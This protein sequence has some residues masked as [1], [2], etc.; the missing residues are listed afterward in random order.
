MHRLKQ[1][2]PLLIQILIVC[3]V[4]LL[5]L[6]QY[7]P[8]VGMDYKYFIPRLIDSH[9]HY[10]IN[11][12]SIQWYTPSFGGGL[13]S[14]PNPQQIQ[15]SLPQAFTLFMD[16]WN[17]SLAAICVF[18]ALG[19]LGAYLLSKKRLGLTTE[20]SLTVALF[21]TLNGFTL[22][23]L[24]IGHLTFMGY[25][26]LPLVILGLT[27]P[28]N[29]WWNSL[30]VGWVMAVL[31]Y[32]G[33]FYA[34]VYIIFAC[35]LFLPLAGLFFP[36]A[37]Q[38]KFY[39]RNATIG[40]II[41]LA[42]SASKLY[43][44]LSFLRSFPRAIADEY[45][46][47]FI[48]G[49]LAIPLQLLGSMSLSFYG[50]AT[51]KTHKFTWD[52]LMTYTGSNLPVWE[53]DIS[54]S[55]ALF[56]LMIVGVTGILANLWKNKVRLSAQQWLNALALVAVGVV[57]VEFITTKGQLYA[58]L[59]GLPI[60][61]SLHVNP[62][63]TAVLILPLSILA[64][65][66]LD[67][68]YRWFFR[69]AK[70]R[71]ALWAII[72]AITIASSS[73]YFLLPMDSLQRRQFSVDGS[74]SVW[75][76]IRAGE[77]YAV[78]RILDDLNDARVFDRHASTLTPYEVLFGYGMREFTPKLAEGD[79]LTIT[80]GEFNLNDPTGFVFGEVNQSVPF[81]RIKLADQDKLEQFARREQPNWVIPLGQHLS[82]GISLAMVMAT[83]LVL[84]ARNTNVGRMMSSKLWR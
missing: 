13:P 45:N 43:A 25:L 64:G 58:L 54:L 67:V 60:L 69:S 71:I 20:A 41:A 65:L 14:Y 42:L 33:G 77:R 44:V 51:G 66:S 23:H 12:L 48:Q 35:L 6:G 70:A 29:L 30:L 52:L 36:G 16:P 83:L 84:L 21:F 17:A 81:D 9:L 11:G 18:I 3:G 22:Q 50:M 61:R 46:A 5:S 15:F 62:R 56:I 32:G 27:A 31:L 37:V 73:I 34:I 1:T 72:L 75:S 59:S 49:L 2:Y 26:L 78:E 10:V 74:Q 19:N 47:S 79:I 53:L 57:L 55:P 24:G 82:N 40:G 80:N 4:Y 76:Q 68:L 39:V 63:Y 8:Q 7:Y 28:T 38:P